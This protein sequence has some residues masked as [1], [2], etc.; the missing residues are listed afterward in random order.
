MYYAKKKRA[1]KINI[2][3]IGYYTNSNRRKTKEQLPISGNCFHNSMK[4]S[5]LFPDE[6]YTYEI[7]FFFFCSALIS[8]WSNTQFFCWFSISTVERFVRLFLHIYTTIR[9]KYTGNGDS[10]KYC[11]QVQSKKNCIEL[12]KFNVR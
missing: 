1:D 10:T 3:S 6:R 5:F 11:A 8:K 2:R 7:N 12:K 4:N 9:D